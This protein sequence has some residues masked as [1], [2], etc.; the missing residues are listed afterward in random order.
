M[1][2]SKGLTP[3]PSLTI[4]L[5]QVKDRLRLGEDDSG[6]RT[7]SH[8]LDIISESDVFVQLHHDEIKC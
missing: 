8:N 3:P 7:N 1:A 2:K 4:S 5:S 6:N